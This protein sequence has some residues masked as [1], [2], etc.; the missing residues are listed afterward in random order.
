[1]R[2]QIPNIYPSSLQDTW[3]PKWF[4]KW[5]IAVAFIIIV[6]A[7][8]L[9]RNNLMAPYLYLMYAI[10]ILGFFVGTVSLSRKWATMTPTM[11]VKSVAKYALFLRIV[12]VTIDLFYY[13][14]VNGGDEFYYQQGDVQW[15]VSEALQS[16]QDA[17]NGQFNA[18]SRIRGYG[19]GVDDLG[20]IMYLTVVYVLTGCMSLAYIPML[21]NAVLGTFTCILIYRVAQRHFGETVSRWTAL[22]CMLNPSM[23]WWCGSLMKETVMVFLTVWFADLMDQVIFGRKFTFKTLWPA[24]AVGMYLLTYR[25]ALA[26][27]CFLAFFAAVVFASNRIVSTGK[28]IIAGFIVL[29]VLIAGFGDTLMEQT[30]S[31]YDSVTIGGQQTNMEWRTTREHGNQFAKYASATVF[32][33]LIFTIPFPTLSYTHDG[34][35]VLMQVAGGN[36]VKNITSFFVIFVLLMMLFSGDWRSHVFPAALMCGYLLVMVMSSYAQSGR[37]HMPI[38]PFEM[39]FAAYGVYWARTKV[40]YREWFGYALFIEFVACIGW[41]YFKLKG[42]GLM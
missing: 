31:M 17:Y 4:Q 26:V 25:A 37:F 23:I 16:A 41:Q 29:L 18:F 12:W 2:I 21:L 33:P 34:Q 3:I 32:A 9:F 19:V 15:Y 30:Q 7:A 1:M 39:M 24:V 8:V 20:Y 22:F 6:V 38:I 13:R 42:Q 36:V 11:F 14:S 35:I 40:K 27:V 5:S 10:E 28:K